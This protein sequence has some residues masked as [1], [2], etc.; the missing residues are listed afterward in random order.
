MGKKGKARLYTRVSTD[1]QA[2]RHTSTRDQEIMLRKYCEDNNYEVLAVYE[3]NG[4]SSKN[5]KRPALQ[6]LLSEIQDDEFVL[7]T[8]LD[9]L[10]RNTRDALNLIYDWQTRGIAVKVSQEMDVDTSTAD[11]RLRLEIMLSVATF[12]REHTSDRIRD[13]FRVKRERGEACGGT[14]PLGYAKDDHDHYII[15]E[16]GADMVRWT[17]DTFLECLSIRRTKALFNQK[18][19]RNFSKDRIR[20]MLRNKAYIGDN[21]HEA[22]LDESVFERVQ[23]SLDKR[24]HQEKTKHTYIFSGLTVCGECGNRM[25]GNPS[26]YRRKKKDGTTSETIFL[27]YRCR[28]EKATTSSTC[29]QSKGETKLEKLVLAQLK[30]DLKKT[31]VQGALKQEEIGQIAEKIERLQARKR[32]LSDLYLD[33]MISREEMRSKAADIEKEITELKKRSK[34]PVKVEVDS[35]LLN[36]YP[37]LTKKQKQSFWRNILEEIKVYNNDR[38]ELFYREE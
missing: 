12:E 34:A 2:Q 33:E 11:G 8:R 14:P 25:T 37:S 19:E 7:I 6:R 32:R 35:D 10:S 26:M 31:S 38:V 4:F 27:N 28:K 20:Y 16:R 29:C 22:I 9:R 36:E 13:T 23:E 1:E 30:A 21:F 17:Y 3:D 18:F 5:L 15:D 24:S